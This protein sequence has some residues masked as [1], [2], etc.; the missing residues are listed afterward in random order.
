MSRGDV[1]TTLGT[2]SWRDQALRNVSVHL[3]VT[4]SLEQLRA[5]RIVIA[6]RLSTIKRADQIY[7]LAGGALV[8]HGTY[9]QLLVVEGTFGELVRRQQL[10][11]L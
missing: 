1:G 6:H 9:D 5:T 2:L 10:A 3:V 11:V 7:V 4:R 8:Q